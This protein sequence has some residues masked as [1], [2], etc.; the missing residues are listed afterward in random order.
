[1][2]VVELA[3]SSHNATTTGLSLP[4]SVMA[5]QAIATV[6]MRMVLKSPEQIIGLLF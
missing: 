5:L 4:C 6:K 1:M 2:S 3:A